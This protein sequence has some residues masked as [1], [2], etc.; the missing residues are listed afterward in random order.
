MSSAAC[1]TS[2]PTPMTKTPN[3]SPHLSRG[4]GL[5]TAY[6][7]VTRGDGGQNVL[8]PEFGDE[9]G[10][11][12]T[13]ELLA[14]RRLDGGRQFFTRAID[15][16]FSKDYRETLGIWDRQQVTGDIVRVIR[17]FRPDVIITRFS[18]EPGGT[19]GHH[20]ASAVLALDAFKAAGDPKAFPEQLGELKPWQPKRIFVNSRNDRAQAKPEVI[21]FDISGTDAVSGESFNAI[22]ARSRS[23]HRSQGFGNFAGFGA[24]AGPRMESFQLL[25]GAP[26]QKDILDG[27]E[28]TWARYTGGDEIARMA[29][30]V[31]AN[32]DPKNASASVP[33]LLKLRTRLVGLSSDPIVAEKS[34]QLDRIIQACAGLEV[35]TIVSQAE[36]VPGEALAMHMTAVVHSS[37]PVRW[38][39]VRY[40]STKAHIDEPLN[41]A[42][43]QP[44]TRE[45][46]QTIPVG[47]PITQ[48]Y[49][50]REQGTAGMYHV[51]DPSLIGTPES[52]PAFVVE[53]VFEI[54]GQTLVLADEP[55]QL[56]SGRSKEESRHRLN[57]I[58]PVS[59]SFLSDVRLFP[60]S[61]SRPVE[62]EVVA[63]R[64]DVA[65]TLG[66][67]VPAGWK[68]SPDSQPFHLG[69]VGEH[70]KFT[71]SVS[72][73][74]EPATGE[75][76]AHAV[77][78]G[79]IFGSRRIEIHYEHIPPQLLQPPT[80]AKAVCLD[81]STRGHRVGYVPG[82]GDSIAEALQEMGYS[83]TQLT[84]ADLTPEHLHDL[85]AVVIGIRAFNVRKDLVANLPALF[86]FAE[87]GGNVIIQY[88]RPDG[89]QDTKIAPYGL[90]LS[91]DRVTDEHAA[92]TFLV[93]DSPVLNTPN[94]ITSADF[95]GWVQERGVYFPNQWDEHFT[96]I[97]ACGDP[98]EP[99][100]KGGLLVAQYGQGHIV[101][102][103]LAW[104]RQLPAGVP[105]AYRLFA[106]LVSMDK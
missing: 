99:A 9:L 71:F 48:P 11:I 96:P 75:L 86:A 94:K 55:V 31:I 78:N 49:W 66:I 60:R 57:I 77:V 104:F 30:E 91:G 100:L 67:S 53:Q 92:V 18:T 93:P 88:N 101:Y 54:G 32:F 29:D 51:S 80:I 28:T 79:A 95:D 2:R 97:L 40:P 7:S 105:G 68:V 14:A 56:S 102:T 83:V 50:L 61:G 82:A 33:G 12:R 5:R 17:T 21:S 90:H 23:M 52:S 36:I 59:T 35:Q 64:N 25:D 27:V 63:S 62:V 103:G 8:G 46:T 10:V 39:G 20:T 87:S 34:V 13:Q 6:L 70:A 89:L 74:A 44:A 76:R 81:L 15:F 47:T 45:S 43:E 37:V 58:P 65:G 22:A 26:A 69:L 16:G 72:A 1:Y 84:G 38:L 106:N 19:H 42:P 4:R 3:S 85:D 98:G 24:G 41:L 73:P